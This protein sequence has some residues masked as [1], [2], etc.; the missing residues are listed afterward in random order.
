MTASHEAGGSVHPSVGEQVVAALALGQVPRHTEIVPL[1]LGM[2]RSDLSDHSIVHT[3]GHVD[4]SGRVSARSMLALLGWGAGEPMSISSCREM[5]VLR[6]RSSGT[7]RVRSS[8]FVSIPAAA[9]AATGIKVGETV[10]ITAVLDYDML[11]VHSQASV[12]SMVLS[13]IRGLK[14][15]S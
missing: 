5:I 14:A 2:L 3:L 8:R 12:N 6:R 9:R 13:R 11:V 4:G 1:R 7:D 10:L 15:T